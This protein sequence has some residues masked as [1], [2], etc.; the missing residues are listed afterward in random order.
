MLFILFVLIICRLLTRVCEFCVTH[1]LKHTVYRGAAVVI[2]AFDLSDES[3]FKHVEKW[4]VYIILLFDVSRLNETRSNV[5]G[6]YEVFMA[7]MKSDLAHAVKHET[8]AQLASNEKMQYFE[9]SA[10]HSWGV[11]EMFETIASSQ[12]NRHITELIREEATMGK[13]SIA[14]SDSMPTVSLS[15]I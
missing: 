7:G 2:I 9:C 14:R 4:S 11:T 5:G 15:T 1:F 6:Q 3:S 10:K 12:F 8:A 13:P